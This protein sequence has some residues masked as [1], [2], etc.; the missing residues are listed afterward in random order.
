V[1]QGCE[2]SLR[3]VADAITFL[4]M[5]MVVVVVAVMTVVVVCTDLWCCVVLRWRDEA[6]L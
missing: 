1:E 6:R 3:Y 4:V 2:F 5:M